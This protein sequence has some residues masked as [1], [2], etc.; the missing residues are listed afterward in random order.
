MVGT[1]VKEDIPGAAYNSTGFRSRV[2]TREK[3]TWTISR[4]DL[5]AGKANTRPNRAREFPSCRWPTPARPTVFI[6]LPVDMA[7]DVHESHGSLPPRRG[8]SEAIFLAASREV[9]KICRDSATVA[10]FAVT[11][12]RD[13][14]KEQEKY[15]L[16]G[17]TYTLEQ[18]AELAKPTI[19]VCV[20]RCRH[21]VL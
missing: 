5:C 12:R 17:K 11:V 6:G 14:L 10:N 19:D 16:E 18:R 8:L 1:V 9:S 15:F 21:G 7:T 20:P 13:P 2:E 3:P 4:K